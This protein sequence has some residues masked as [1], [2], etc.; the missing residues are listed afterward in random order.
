MKILLAVDASEFSD[1][2]V[3]QVAAR[4]WPPGTVICVYSV[5]D[6]AR[7]G[8]VAVEAGLF[9]S[10]LTE[11]AEALVKRTGARLAEQGLHTVTEV[12]LGPC[13][14]TIVDYARSWEA[15]FIFVGSHGRRGIT[16]FLLGGVSRAVL[17]KAPCSVVVAKTDPRGTREARKGIRILLATDGSECSLAAA[18]SIATRPWPERTEVKILAV[19]DTPGLEAEPW[20]V[21]AGVMEDLRAATTRRAGEA[22]ASAEEV[23]AKSGLRPTGSVLTGEPRTAILE[24]ADRWGADL[25]VAGSHGRR[26]LNRL[27]LGSVSEGLVVHAKCTVEVIRG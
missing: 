17:H 4:I 5:I 22:V 1:E 11:D 25:I 18:R 19:A 12:G 26:G 15:D 13:A 14:S 23:L 20:Y 2:A 7:F 16:R 3:R 8:E 24:M 21:N 27:L 10:G 9:T 6:L